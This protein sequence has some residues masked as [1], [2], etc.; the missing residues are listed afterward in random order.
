MITRLFQKLFAWRSN[1]LTYNQ[2]V[3]SF[4]DV[5]Q[6]NSQ[7]PVTLTYNQ[8][9]YLFVK[10]VGKISLLCNGALILRITKNVSMIT[11]GREAGKSK[12]LEIKR[13]IFSSQTHFSSSNSHSHSP[14][15]YSDSS[16][17]SDNEHRFNSCD[18]NADSSSSCDSGGGDSGGSD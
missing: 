4:N 11:I 10:A 8:N 2:F 7:Y 14:V 13:N 3:N 12:I 15:I 5:Y 1:S 17:F 18:D 6:I 16:S 9:G